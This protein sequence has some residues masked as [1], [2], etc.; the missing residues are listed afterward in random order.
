MN[1]IKINKK[2]TG[3][4]KII[5]II[6]TIRKG[7]TGSEDNYRLDFVLQTFSRRTHHFLLF[8]CRLHTPLTSHLTVQS[9]AALLLRLRP[10]GRGCTLLHVS[11]LTDD[12]SRS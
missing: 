1:K 4:L 6:I 8:T 2:K 11:A 3:K 5:K 10:G 9:D 7:P 12:S